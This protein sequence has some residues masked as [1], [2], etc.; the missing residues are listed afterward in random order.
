MRA[1][2]AV[3]ALMHRRRD[4]RFAPCALRVATR[5]RPQA[6]HALNARPENIKAFRAQPPASSARREGLRAKLEQ[7]PA[8]PAPLDGMRRTRA[9]RSATRATSDITRRLQ[10]R[11]PV[12]RAIPARM[13]VNPEARCVISAPLEP[14]RV[15]VG[16]PPAPPAK[17]EA[18][19]RT[20]VRR[21]AWPA[22]FPASPACTRYRRA[23]ARP[24]GAA[25]S[26]LQLFYAC[27]R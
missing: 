1:H 8:I 18:M 12:H 27:R 23:R 20:S 16:P 9:R 19:R 13:R 7:P 11:R 2:R 22:R 26:A 24:I 21:S 25:E 5:I 4:R 15:R 3:P 6:R 14:L 17:R 10:S